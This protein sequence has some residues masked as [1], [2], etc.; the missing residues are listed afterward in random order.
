MM[1]RSK[2]IALARNVF[3]DA[4]PD[5]RDA[6][7]REVFGPEYVIEEVRGMECPTGSWATIEAMKWAVN[8]DSLPDACKT[9]SN[10]PRNGGS[11]ICL[12]TLGTPKIT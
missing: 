10:H 3:K 1:T 9:C 12:C 4:N 7:I 6:F 2:I 5:E 11:G 8:D